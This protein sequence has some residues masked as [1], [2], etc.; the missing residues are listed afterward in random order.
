MK[1]GRVTG[2]PQRVSAVVCTRGREKMA[3]RAV[4]SLVQQAAEEVLVI[5]NAPPDDSTLRLVRARFP[6]V[7]YFLEPV[8]GLDFARNR[9]L[10]EATGD[11]VAFLDDDAVAAPGW[12][13]AFVR[14]FR[15]S[16]RIAC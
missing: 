3:A 9:A 11:I 5:D 15:A 6:Q 10:R 1:T 4:A 16:P 12:S 2:A 7:R 8:E 13:A 14:A